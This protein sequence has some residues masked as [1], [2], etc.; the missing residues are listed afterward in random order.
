M[1]RNGS[2]PTLRGQPLDAEGDEDTDAGL[3][4][5]QKLVLQRAAYDKYVNELVS[6]RLDFSCADENGGF[7]HGVG[8]FII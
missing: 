7:E 5:T 1:I 4:T 6:G 8:G 2:P 3:T